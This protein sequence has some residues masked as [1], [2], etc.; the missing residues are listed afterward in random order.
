VCRGGGV[1][2]LAGL[3]SPGPDPP[4]ATSPQVDFPP[5]AGQAGRV[6]HPKGIDP[7]NA[8][9]DPAKKVPWSS[10]DLTSDEPER[11]VG[12]RRYPFLV[13][14]TS[15][16][17]NVRQIWWPSDDRKSGYLGRWGPRVTRDPKGRRAGMAFPEFWKMFFNAL[18]DARSKP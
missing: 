8:P 5:N 1:A 7:P 14:R 15:T 6:V 11:K 2:G 17:P 4:Q 18:A 13:D 3:Q 12:S 9:A 16:D 10:S